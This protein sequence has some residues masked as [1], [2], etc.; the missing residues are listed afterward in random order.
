MRATCSLAPPCSGP[1]SV[2][3]AAMMLEY[4]PESVLEVTRAENA[5]AFSSWSACRIRQVSNWRTRFADGSRP[6]SM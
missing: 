5:D 2:P 4:M 1:F 3:I 6:C